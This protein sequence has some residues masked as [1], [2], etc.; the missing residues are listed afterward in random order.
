MVLNTPLS[1]KRSVYYYNADACKDSIEAVVQRC[2]VKKVFLENLQNSQEN[3][4]TRVSF[5]RAEAC[6]FTKKETLTQV[7]SG[8]FCEISR[9]T[10]F[11]RTPLG[12]ASV[13]KTKWTA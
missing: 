9:N 7:L 3:T 11:H 5:C 8:E 6:K 2:S 4:R 10:F 13:I 12:A 1:H